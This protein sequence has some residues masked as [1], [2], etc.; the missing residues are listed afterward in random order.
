MSR[1]RRFSKK[2]SGEGIPALGFQL[3]FASVAAYEI[4]AQLGF[5]DVADDF[6]SIQA[7]YFIVVGEGD[8]EE[9]LVVLAAIEGCRNEVH[10]ELLGHD[11]GLVVDGDAVFVNPASD[12]ATVTAGC[13]IERIAIYN[14]ASGAEALNVAGNGQNEMTIDVA[15]LSKGVYIVRINNVHTLKLIKR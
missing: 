5:R 15:G 6:Y 3:Y 9:K 12:V 13:P 14:A 7:L 1:N 10:V 2:S 8:G 4:V 11:C